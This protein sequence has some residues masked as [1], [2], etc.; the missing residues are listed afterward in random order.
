[1]KKKELNKQVSLP[2]IYVCTKMTSRVET[3]RGKARDAFS[4]CKK[5][6]LLL[7]SRTFCDPFTFYSLSLLGAT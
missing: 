6:V 4:R 5:F 2:S 3:F 1:M 7:F